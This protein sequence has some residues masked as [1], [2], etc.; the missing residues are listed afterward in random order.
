MEEQGE[1]AFQLLFDWYTNALK[2]LVDAAG[3]DKAIELLAPYNRN[4][5]VA[6]YFIAHDFYQLGKKDLIAW[7]FI[8][9]NLLFFMTRSPNVRVNIY[10][11]GSTCSVIKCPFKDGPVEHCL[12]ICGRGPNISLEA[13]GID[14]SSS[15]VSSI[16]QG[17]EE[18]KWISK[19]R[20]VKDPFSMEAMGT[21]LCT[22][23]PW[24]VPQQQV[25][26]FSIQYY[27]EWWVSATRAL[28]D[29][30]GE[31]DAEA[32][33]RPYMARSGSR[34]VLRPAP[35]QEKT[36]TQATILWHIVQTNELL[37]MHSSGTEGDFERTIIDCP[38]KE[39]PS[40]VCKQFEAFCNG[41]CEA[42]DPSYEFKYDRMMTNGDK[43]CHW[44]IKA[45]EGAQKIVNEKAAN[46]DP[47]MNLALRLSR[48]QITLEE[49]EKTI[50]SLRKH[51][52]IR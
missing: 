22:I 32:V 52:L 18:C 10:S 48:G 45:K 5:M 20:P 6:A 16:S 47:A 14:T 3:Q 33:L 26:A 25:D 2:A 23:V 37:Q 39:A 13:F 9:W 28:I 36:T 24:D 31:S 51:G 15:L 46:E 43:T 35:C 38:F 40:T 8:V 17:D 4:A 30:I 34:Y 1:R 27:A 41:I 42:I 12:L 11:N 49:F 44:A 19:R 50:A 29:H 7:G 21:H